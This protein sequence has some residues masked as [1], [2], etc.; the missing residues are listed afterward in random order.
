MEMGGRR[1]KKKGRTGS[2]MGRDRREV[3][4]T[5]RMKTTTTKTNKQ[6]HVAVVGRKQGKPPR[7][8]GTKRLP[9]P[10]DDNIE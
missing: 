3:Q 1:K 5:R 6:K 9:G 7:H 2:G 10:S 4:R 8:Q